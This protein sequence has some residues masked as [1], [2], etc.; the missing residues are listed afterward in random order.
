[1]HGTQICISQCW[2]SNGACAPALLLLFLQNS[3]LC[4][5]NWIGPRESIPFIRQFCLLKLYFA[6]CI[7]KAMNCCVFVFHSI[8]SEVCKTSAS[9]SPH[10]VCIFWFSLSES[11]VHKAGWISHNILP[12]YIKPQYFFLN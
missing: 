6:L 12:D 9:S 1:M 8:Q 7:E 5:G 10:T 11:Q 2:C 4:A 3:Q